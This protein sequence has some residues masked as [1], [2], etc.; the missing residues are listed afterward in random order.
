[1]RL[2]YDTTTSKELVPDNG[3]VVMKGQLVVN[4]AV[5]LSMHT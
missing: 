2:C 4:L 1:M 5:L 3:Y